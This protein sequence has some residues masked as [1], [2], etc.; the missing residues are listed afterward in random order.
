MI[1]FDV[2]TGSSVH[3]DYNKKDILIVAK[4]PTATDGL[5]ETT[6]TVHETYFIDFT[7][8]LKQLCSTLYYHELNS[9][10][11]VKGIEIYK[12]RAKDAEINAVRLWLSNFPEDFLVD[13]MKMTELYRYVYDFTVD[14]GSIHVKLW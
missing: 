7:E 6:V 10:T 1:I 9:Y 4:G 11:F 5:D 13:N 2:D 3:I 14:Y 12:F 8:Q